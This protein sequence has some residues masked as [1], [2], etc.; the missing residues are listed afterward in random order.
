MRIPQSLQHDLSSVEGAPKMFSEYARQKGYK[1]FP[2]EDRRPTLDAS[3]SSAE[4]FAGPSWLT[5]HEEPELPPLTRDMTADREAGF[6]PSDPL[7]WAELSDSQSED[8]KGRWSILMI[9]SN[10]TRYFFVRTFGGGMQGVAQ[11]CR[12]ANDDA[13]LVIRKKAIKNIARTRAVRRDRE[14]RMAEEIHAQL[15]LL[16]RDTFRHRFSILLSDETLPAHDAE[17]AF[18]RE[19]WWAYCDAGGNLGDFLT[20]LFRQNHGAGRLVYRPHALILNLAHQVLLALQW[21]NGRGIYHLDSH[22]K[23]IFLAW[24]NGTLVPVVGDFGYARLESEPPFNSRFLFYPESGLA[25]G[26]QSGL[27]SPP[28]DTDNLGPDNRLPSDYVQFLESLRVLLH[29]VFERSDPQHEP[30]FNAVD[31]LLSVGLQ[32]RDDNQLPENQRPPRADITAQIAGFKTA[33]QH[34]L[35]KGGAADNERALA[36]W[37][38]KTSTDSLD[39]LVFNTCTEAYDAAHAQLGDQGPYAVVNV[40]DKASVHAGV[41]RL[42]AARGL[43]NETSNGVHS[44]PGGADV[45][46]S[47]GFSGGGS[48]SDHVD[49]P[50]TPSDNILHQD[51]FNISSEPGG[52]EQASQKYPSA[53]ANTDGLLGSS[54][55]EHAS[56]ASEGNH[57]SDDDYDVVDHPFSTDATCTEPYTG[58]HP[59]SQYIPIPR[60]MDEVALFL[61]GVKDAQHQI[62]QV[63]DQAARDQARMLTLV[64]RFAPRTNVP[65]QHAT[66]SWI[67]LRASDAGDVDVQDLPEQIEEAERQTQRGWFGGIRRRFL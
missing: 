9:D 48:S 40:L 6:R 56:S 17:H 20:F 54:S 14:S 31:T 19:S 51:Y 43:R 63:R 10:E 29:I 55:S 67:Q 18:F 8:V 21:L 28:G 2:D 11:L 33:E 16:P 53:L 25:N 49:Q 50:T 58:L 42:R 30:M 65:L 39:V 23:N 1:L 3:E 52:P 26:Q 44:S 37:R 60:A 45:P 24:E 5:A 32:E 34:Y 4:D 46:L 7:A 27:S 22:A 59:T 64:R 47:S 66:E 15:D 57:D 13:Q 38:D 36:A 12:V 41:A 35:A 62:C 61:A